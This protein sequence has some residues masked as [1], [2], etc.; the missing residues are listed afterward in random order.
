MFISKSLISVMSVVGALALSGCVTFGSKNP[1]IPKHGVS[2][3]LVGN[4]IS[5]GSGINV[6]S[7]HVGSTMNSSS[8]AKHNVSG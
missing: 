3:A 4:P 2:Q 6:G 1:G 8:I 7:G 5:S